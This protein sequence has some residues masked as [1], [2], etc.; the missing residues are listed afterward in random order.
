M[1]AN[2]Q[3]PQERFEEIERFLQGRMSPGEESGF[4]QRLSADGDLS[5]EVEDVRILLVGIEESALE[6]RLDA[7][8]GQISVAPA[9]PFYR[10]AWLAAAVIGF[11]IIG[12]WWLLQSAPV[13]KQLFTEY[14]HPDPGLA[15][16]MGSAENYAFER[17][18][19]DYKTG[20]YNEALKDWKQLQASDAAS[21]TLDYFI[22]SAY[23][24]LKKSDSAA[25]YF[26]KVIADDQS[27]FR[28]DAN[29][30]LGLSL[31]LENRMTEAIPYIEQSS[32]NEKESLLSKLKQ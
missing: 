27:L 29:W 17:A 14:F 5:K 21:D 4:R 28:E 16:S 6:E 30:Y 3:I 25:V 1:T 15:T 11:L 9:A 8:H 19:V 31:L 22:G 7:Y 24:G 26:R 20:K 10:R 13:N 18:M 23:L 12:A 32:H 2:N